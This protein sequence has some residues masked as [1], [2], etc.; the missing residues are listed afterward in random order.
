MTWVSLPQV[1][2]GPAWELVSSRSENPAVLKHISHRAAAPALGESVAPPGS[3]VMMLSPVMM[4]FVSL[5][6]E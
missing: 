4:F 6:G 2:E 1:K 5:A 3:P